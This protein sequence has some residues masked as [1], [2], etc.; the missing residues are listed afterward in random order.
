MAVSEVKETSPE[1]VS[2]ELSDSDSSSSALLTSTQTL[3]SRE[4]LP[5]QLPSSALILAGFALTNLFLF[6]SL[7]SLDYYAVFEI[8]LRGLFNYV[9]LFLGLALYA[10]LAVPYLSS[11]WKGIRSGIFKEELNLGLALSILALYSIYASLFDVDGLS[12]LPLSESL[13]VVASL[14]VAKVWLDQKLH[15]IRQRMEAFRLSDLVTQLCLIRPSKSE[16]ESQSEVS[17]ARQETYI[18]VDSARVGD[19]FRVKMGE[20][21]PC[22]AVVL[23]GQAEIEERLLSGSGQRKYCGPGDEIF[24]GSSVIKGE[25]D[26]RILLPF[27]EASLTSMHDR[28]QEAIDT[29]GACQQRSRRFRQIHNVGL[30]ALALISGQ[31]LQVAGAPFQA[32]AAV[33]SSILL[34]SCVPSLLRVSAYLYRLALVSAY[35]E[36]ILLKGVETIDALREAQS[37]VVDF[38]SECPPVEEQVTSFAML[39]DRIAQSSLVN[40][41][42]L[43]ASQAGDDFY[44]QLANYCRE[45]LSGAPE[46]SVIDDFHFYGER[47]LTGNIQ[48]AELSL[49]NESFLIERGA[50]LQAS[51]VLMEDEQSR[52]LYVAVGEELVARFEIRKVPDSDC[53]QLLTRLRG[54]GLRLLLLSQDTEA[55]TDEYGQQLGLE[56]SD[57]SSGLDLEAYKDKLQ[58]LQPVAFFANSRTPDSVFSDS[59]VSISVFDQVRWELDRTDVTLFVERFS[60]LGTLFGLVR[61][62]AAVRRLNLVCASVL[63]V[64]LLVLAFAGLIAPAVVLVSVMLFSLFL[65]SNLLRLVHVRR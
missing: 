22:D 63:T 48:G 15:C 16:D 4:D 21:I 5:I 56:L 8:E 47:G 12:R 19:S 13:I 61:K 43:L 31:M 39:D 45:N 50:Q 54:W 52:Y 51:E 2:S 46:H 6:Y 17:V 37:L 57:I 10:C 64:L 14:L 55:C 11:G 30:L 23:E 27:A 36:G 28:L 58:R 62:F 33:V 53:Q 60:L 24:A 44:F 38:N 34:I 59:D 7:L 26:C 42:I 49:G 25:L 32:V 1:L 35:R 9:Y 20:L 40:M 18:D 29:T 65:H 41:L 3:G